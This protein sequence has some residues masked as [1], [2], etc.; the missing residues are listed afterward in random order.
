MINAIFTLSETI[1][2]VAHYQDGVLHSQQK[3]TVSNAS[4]GESDKYEELFVNPALITLARQRGE[5]DCGGLDHLVIKYGHF[6][7]LILPLKAGHLSICIE[8]T[9]DPLAIADQLKTSGI[10]SQ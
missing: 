4:T 6:Y 3:S 1:R 7:Q 9:G 10:I 2:Y 8:S 5:L